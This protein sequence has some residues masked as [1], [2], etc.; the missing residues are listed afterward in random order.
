MHHVMKKNTTIAR[1]IWFQLYTFPYRLMYMLFTQSQLIKKVSVTTTSIHRSSS[2][3][4]NCITMNNFYK[5]TYP[6]IFHCSKKKKREESKNYWNKGGSFEKFPFR[7]KKVGRKKS[8]L[9]PNCVH[10]TWCPH[11]WS[12]TLFDIFCNGCH[13]THV[14]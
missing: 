14:Y 12:G 2:E 11:N 6:S 10:I 9:K 8:S 13:A 5:S 7:T 3:K 4:A 1:T